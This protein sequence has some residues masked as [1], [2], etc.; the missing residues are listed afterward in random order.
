MTGSPGRSDLVRLWSDLVR[1]W[2]DLVRFL[3][4]E[5]IQKNY[6]HRIASADNSVYS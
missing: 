2:S 3:P 6:P 4:R 5:K 1:L